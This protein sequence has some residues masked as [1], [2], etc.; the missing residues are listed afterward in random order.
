[1]E[2][3]KNLS[4]ENIKYFDDDGIQKLEIWRDIH[5]YEGLYQASDL[6]RLKSSN[7]RNTKKAGILTQGNASCGYLNIGFNKNSIHYTLTVHRLI[8]ITFIDNVENKP[9]VNHING[10]KKDN[11]LKN[12]EW[13]TCA[14]NSTHSYKIGLSNGRKGVC[15]HN[16]KLTEKEVL[17]IRASDLSQVE[18]SKKYFVNQTQI[19]RIKT[20]QQWS[21]I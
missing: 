15:H 20:R 14:E 4:L 3:Y 2:Y 6:G 1:M 8:A 17:E 19:S 12:L 5:K 7:Y 10:N 21:H 18:L 13:T 11:R 9:Q 16:M